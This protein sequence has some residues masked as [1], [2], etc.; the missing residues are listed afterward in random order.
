MGKALEAPKLTKL[1]GPWGP[2][3]EVDLPWDNTGILMDIPSVNLLQFAI[4]N[5]P[6]K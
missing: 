5:G 3:F 6:L 2:G 4:E 1:L